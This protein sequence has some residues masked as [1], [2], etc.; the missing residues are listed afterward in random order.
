MWNA[1]PW[2]SGKEEEGDEATRAPS[3]PR[4][5]CAVESILV[6]QPET[7]LHRSILTRRGQKIV[8]TTLLRDVRKIL[9]IEHVERLGHEVNGHAAA[10]RYPLLQT[11]VR[12]VLRW[13]D[14]V[15][16]WD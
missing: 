6:R 9:L 12:L 16:T 10:K 4:L 11:D 5:F 8:R 13:L 14:V 3:R 2:K 1:G 7:Q 15:V